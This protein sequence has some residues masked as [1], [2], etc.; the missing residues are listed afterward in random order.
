MTIAAELV[1]SPAIVGAGR[2]VVGRYRLRA[3]LGR[4]GMGRVW[5]AQDEVLNRQTALKQVVLASEHDNAV[6][7]SA[8]SEARAA[9]RLDHV[10]AVRVHDLVEDGSG[11]WIVMELLS[12]RTLA[13][14]LSSDGPLPLAEV[15]RIG[16]LL[17]DVLQEVHR[18]GL[19]HCD[20]KPANIHLCDDGRVVLTDFGIAR[21]VDDQTTMPSG[22]LAGSPAYMSPERARGDE[23]GAASDLFSLGASLFAAVEGRSPFGRGD[24]FSTL[25]AV[26]EDAPGPFL[27]AGPL[28]PVIEG[29]LAKRPQSRLTADQARLGLCGAQKSLAGAPHARVR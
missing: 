16:L 13:D 11:P 29:L 23:V 26:V 18:A 4:G 24:P 14:T 22:G 8:L 5:L 28:R 17:L 12:G 19:V 9:A 25:V 10:G 3:L 2:L 20:V 21:A 6:R 7:A 1:G 27:N 15:T